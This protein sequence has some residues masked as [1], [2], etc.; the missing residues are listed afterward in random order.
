MKREVPAV[1][2]AVDILELF[3]REGTGALHPREIADMLKIPRSS[4]HD[5][6]TTLESRRLIERSLSD[7]SAFQLGLT[8]LHLGHAYSRSVSLSRVGREAAEFVTR[9]SGETTQVAVLEG[10]EVV[11][12]TKVD[13]TESVRLVSAIGQRLP[14][15]CTGVGKVLLAAL[16]EAELASLFPPG[17]P[18]VGM[19][20][21]SITSSD[22]LAA[23]L[24]R[25]RREGF[26]VDFCESNDSVA[27]VAAP[28]RN[29]T[30]AT[31]AA[32]SVSV[33]ITRW[34]D[35]RAIDL[36]ALA[37]TGADQVSQAYGF[38]M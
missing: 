13:G 17:E 31:V 15:H 18:L 27:C 12:V 8:A 10:R 14:A 6:L 34:D 9:E 26:G 33:P 3:V 35:E 16:P 4:V 20:Q 7:S 28:I 25:I 24:A 38:S 32:L 21:H 23:E 11:Y 36:A 1:N 29:A 5:L 19:T 2:R 22:V 37:R 30:G